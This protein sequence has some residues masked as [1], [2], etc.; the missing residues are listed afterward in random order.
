M[1]LGGVGVPLQLLEERPRGAQQVKS[2]NR[3]IRASVDGVG[4]GP[5]PKHCGNLRCRVRHAEMR[6]SPTPLA[7]HGVSKFR[8]GQN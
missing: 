6:L 8:D 3:V 4:W 1:S 2:L 7:K 5:H